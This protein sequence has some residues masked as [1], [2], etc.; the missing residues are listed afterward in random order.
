[1]DRTMILKFMIA[2]MASCKAELTFVNPSH[3]K[4]FGAD[5]NSYK[6]LRIHRRPL[7]I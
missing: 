3:N 4:A 5:S 6:M 7:A 2:F 1:M